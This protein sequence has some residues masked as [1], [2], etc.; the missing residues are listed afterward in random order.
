MTWRPTEPKP[1]LPGE[2]TVVIQHRT[3]CKH[4]E[5]PCER[6]GTTNERDIVHTARAP[7]RRQARRLARKA[8][9]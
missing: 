9:R 1:E 8:R 6:C 4:G 3:R 5:G 2:W 7:N